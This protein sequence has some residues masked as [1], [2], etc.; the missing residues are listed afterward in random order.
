ME[1]LNKNQII[2]LTLLV[3]FVTSIATGIVTVTL[4]DQAPPAIQQTVNRIVERTI[5]RVVPGEP[6]T[7]TIIKEVPVYITEEQLIVDVINQASPSLMQITDKAGNSLG[8]GFIISADGLIVTAAK[9][10]NNPAERQN[11]GA[12]TRSGQILKCQLVKFSLKDDIAL[13]KID[14]EQWSQAKNNLVAS[15]TSATSTIANVWQ[16]LVLAEETILPGQTVIAL[17]MPDNGPTNVS[18]G[19]ISAVGQN[20]ETGQSLFHTNVVN[21][22]NHG[23]P[24]LNTK[25]KVIGLSQENNTAL[26]AE[27]IKKFF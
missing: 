13:L 17:G 3:S 2:L 14:V 8:S 4:M 5:E 26:S 18:V 15:L 21:Q 19:I 7:E 10:F 6:K 12:I 1:E 25:G 27:A 16:P 23:G 9:I 24:I 20:A 11:F 22:Y